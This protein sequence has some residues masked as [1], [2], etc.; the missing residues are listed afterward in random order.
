MFRDIPFPEKPPVTQPHAGAC[1]K[2]VAAAAP[3]GISAAVSFHEP[4][5]YT[6]V[7]EKRGGVY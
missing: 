5:L 7:S 4:L 6:D 2:S 3:A 1:L